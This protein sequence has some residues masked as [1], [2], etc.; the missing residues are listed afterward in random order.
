MADLLVTLQREFFSLH[1][2]IVAGASLLRPGKLNRLALKQYKPASCY[3]WAGFSF[4]VA[5]GASAQITPNVPSRS[6]IDTC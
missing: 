2:G 3:A 6:I 5:C 1:Q 4:V